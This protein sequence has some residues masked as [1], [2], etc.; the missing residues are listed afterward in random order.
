[1]FILDTNILSDF[2]KGHER[3][4]RRIDATSPDRPVVTSVIS[5]FEII[6][7]RF[8]SLEK[9]ANRKELLIAAE[10]ITISEREL[11]EFELLP[12]T[13]LVADQFE[14]L[15]LNKK[16]KKIGRPDLLI[17]CICLANDATLVTRNVK[18]FVN[19]P[20]LRIENW[21]D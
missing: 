13:D 19:V 9:A 3:I 5:W 7:G 8:R 1:M 4:R 18:D 14:K 20:R 15:L 2:F 16:L 12:I 6:S 21:A 11:G 17:A 10:R